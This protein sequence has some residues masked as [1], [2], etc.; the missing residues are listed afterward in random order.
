DAHLQPFA[1][2]R[3]EAFELRV[4][5]IRAGVQV[6]ELIEALRVG[7]DGLRAVRLDVGDGD[8]NAGQQRAGSVLDR[9]VDGAAEFLTEGGGGEEDEE[10]GAK[11][12]LHDD[13]FR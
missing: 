12:K 11:A 3:L 4:D 7:D 8:G 9:A 10:N 5:A 2:H 6:G 1:H 13:S